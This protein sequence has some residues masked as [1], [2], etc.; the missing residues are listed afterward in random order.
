[1]LI[2]S[3]FVLAS[4]DW[5]PALVLA[6]WFLYF[7][8]NMRRKGESMSHY[9]GFAS[10]KHRTVCFCLLSTLAKSSDSRLSAHP[11][12]KETRSY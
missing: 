10:Y 12:G 7:V 2:Y 8:R 9:P 11:S 6:G 5:Q 1:M 3:G 4:W